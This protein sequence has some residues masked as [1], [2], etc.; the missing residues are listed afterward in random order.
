MLNYPTVPNMAIEKTFILHYM[1]Y[2]IVY[3]YIIIL[4]FNELVSDF[5]HFPLPSI[6]NPCYMVLLQYHLSYDG[7]KHPGIVGAA[8]NHVRGYKN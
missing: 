3:N 2:I 4:T 6:N 5:T 7:F 8:S 1:I